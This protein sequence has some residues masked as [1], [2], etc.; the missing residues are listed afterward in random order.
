VD[1]LAYLTGLP[2]RA[3]KRLISGQW[4]DWNGFSTAALDRLETIAWLLPSYETKVIK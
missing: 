1:L 2:D 4:S 3:D